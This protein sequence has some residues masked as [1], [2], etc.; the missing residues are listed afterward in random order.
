MVLHDG[1]QREADLFGVC[2]SKLVSGEMNLSGD[3]FTD[4]Q[5]DRDIDTAVRVGWTCT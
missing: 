1:V 3:S 2:N 5:V 4:S